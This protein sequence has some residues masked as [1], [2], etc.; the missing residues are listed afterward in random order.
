VAVE[1]K[2]GSST[3]STD[4]GLSEVI[5][6]VGQSSSYR[7]DSERYMTD[8]SIVVLRELEDFEPT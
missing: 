2:R 3:R 6:Y 1:R 4:E 8:I 7:F 5:K